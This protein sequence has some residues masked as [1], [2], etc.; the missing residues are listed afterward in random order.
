MWPKK[1][2]C[3][4]WIKKCKKRHQQCEL[5]SAFGYTFL[6]LSYICHKLL[7]MS[8]DKWDSS[9]SLEVKESPCHPQSSYACK[10]NWCNCLTWKWEPWIMFFA[11]LERPLWKS[12]TLKSHNKISKFI[13]KVQA[14]SL[15]GAGASSGWVVSNR[16]VM[17]FRRSQ[18]D[19]TITNLNQSSG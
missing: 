7:I 6:Y 14:C 5:Q 12:F 11:S 10:W 2:P 13:H 8:S 1:S 19:S 4:L 16:I 9:H 18:I 17:S 3:F 15:S